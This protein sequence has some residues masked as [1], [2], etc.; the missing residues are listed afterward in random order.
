MEGKR[1]IEEGGARNVR[2]ERA[3][4]RAVLGVAVSEE[5]FRSAS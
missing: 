5:R 2:K 4:S 3:E 1:E